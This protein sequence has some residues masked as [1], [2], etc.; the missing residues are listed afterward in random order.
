MKISLKINEF[1]AR[2]RHAWITSFRTRASQR[3][4]K[5]ALGD[6]ENAVQARLRGTYVN[7]GLK[8]SVNKIADIF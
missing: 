2:K 3:R 6:D 4:G 1:F 7:N 8:P 5:L